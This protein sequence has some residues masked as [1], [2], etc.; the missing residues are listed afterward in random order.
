MKVQTIK[1]TNLALRLFHADANLTLIHQDSDLSA[2]G[3]GSVLS[4]DGEVISFSA[5][6]EMEIHDDVTETRTIRTLDD[7]GE[8]LTE[9]EYKCLK[10]MDVKA[11]DFVHDKYTYNGSTW[12]AV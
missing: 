3:K 12:A 7:E 1:G 2:S 4:L 9:R 10:G 5:Y 6:W 11:E 8:V